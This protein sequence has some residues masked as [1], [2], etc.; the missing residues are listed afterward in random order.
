MITNPKGDG[1]ILI[2]GW[3]IQAGSVSNAILEFKND[4]WIKLDEALKFGRQYPLAFPVQL[5]LTSCGK[6]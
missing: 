3:N 6:N 1:V 4:N 2:G 5:D